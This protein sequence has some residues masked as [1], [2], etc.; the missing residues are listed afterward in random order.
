MRTLPW[1]L[2][3]AGCPADPADPC[4][5]G[6][7]PAAEVGDGREGAFVPF[8]EGT[9]IDVVWGPQ[10]GF[11]VELGVKAVNLPGTRPG[12]ATFYQG[13]ALAFLADDAD[14]QVADAVMYLR[15]TCER[16]HDAQVSTGNAMPLWAESPDE[17]GGEAI[18][19]ELTLTSD[20]GDTLAATS[21]F[22]LAP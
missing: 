4:A 1:L 21:T 16:A 17:L 12:R 22:T 9:P 19:V 8:A 18:R 5:E 6:G 15:F 11:H 14:T 3:L 10:G 20:D 13:A 2:L 7:D